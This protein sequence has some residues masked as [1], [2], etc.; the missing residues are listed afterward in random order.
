MLH[1]DAVRQE[2]LFYSD[3]ETNLMVMTELASLRRGR[4]CGK[5]CRHCAYQHSSVLSDS[6]API[7][8]PGLE[9]QR[10][11][12]LVVEKSQPSKESAATRK[13]K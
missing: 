11:A 7:T 8:T 5:A 4:C 1:A 12:G 6:P 13:N 3:P 2:K 9:E 10:A